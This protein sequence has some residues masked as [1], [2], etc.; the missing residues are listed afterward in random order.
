MGLSVSCQNPLLDLQK[1]GNSADFGVA[2]QGSVD[3]AK[4]FSYHAMVGNGTGTSGEIDQDKK[5]YLSLTAR[6]VKGMVAEAYADFENREGKKDRY[7]LQGFL[8]YQVDTFRLGAQVA[9][10]TRK[11]GEGKDN[12]N[13]FGVSAFG[14]AQLIEQKVWALAR[15]D[16]MF[17]PN[18]D[19]ERIAYTPYVATAKSNTIILG[20]DWTPIKD[21]HI[22]PNL[23]LVFYDA[24]DKADKPNTDVMPRLTLYYIY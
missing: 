15:F 19:G 7:T 4:K 5:V 17:D 3:A 11:Q 16:R 1:L 9:N 20:I 10:Q 14:A 6:P 18:P 22:I 8:A 12:V 21:V 23:F 13:L 2:V 24:P